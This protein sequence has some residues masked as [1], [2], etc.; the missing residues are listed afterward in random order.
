M[1]SMR[2][3]LLARLLLVAGVSSACGGKSEIPEPDL[4]QEVTSQGDAAGQA[5]AAGA[6]GQGGAGQGGAG[7]G[8]SGGSS[9][10]GG[11]G[12]AGG[13]AIEG[14][15]TSGA[16]V[17]ESW[18]KPE[19][20]VAPCQCQPEGTY[21]CDQNPPMFSSLLICVDPSST[22]CPEQ[23]AP[24]LSSL[25]EAEYKA[26]CPYISKGPLESK[27]SLGKYKCCYVVEVDA[28][29]GRPLWV[30]GERHQAA[31]ARAAGWG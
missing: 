18:C 5:G 13:G 12:G 21:A 1:A 19:Y 24:E 29:V 15:K 11:T 23:S 25:I 14:C 3:V 7:A 27:D 8:G 28:C 22:G 31:L 17:P 9:A 10:A 30:S 4:N 26:S 20:D 2:D 6:A 16:C